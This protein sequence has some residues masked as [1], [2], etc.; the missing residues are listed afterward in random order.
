MSF[1]TKTSSTPTPPRTSQ[2]VGPYLLQKTLGKGQ[3]G[4]YSIV[5][6]RNIKCM[7]N[8]LGLVKLGVHYV[9]TEK[10]AIKIVN[11]EAL[12]ESVLM[13]VNILL[14]TMFSIIDRYIF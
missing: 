4:R 12:S 13:K 7:N 8:N 14:F 6:M 5:F 11:R 9:T 2:Y 10:V 3:T 1:N